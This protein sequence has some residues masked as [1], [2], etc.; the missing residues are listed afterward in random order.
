MQNAHFAERSVF[1]NNEDLNLKNVD[2]KLEH[3]DLKLKMQILNL[4]PA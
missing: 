4:N 2:L 3:V 1:Q